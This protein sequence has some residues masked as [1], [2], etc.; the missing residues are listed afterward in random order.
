MLQAVSF[1]NLS[2]KWHWLYA[3]IH[4]RCSAE[5]TNE[6]VARVRGAI[7]ESLSQMICNVY[8]IAKLF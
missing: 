2:A 1:M 8:N 3:R 4:V 6:N 5:V 7:P